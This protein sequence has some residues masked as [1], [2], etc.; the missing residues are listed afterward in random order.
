MLGA[1]FWLGC[2]MAV[3]S[4]RGAGCFVPRGKCGVAKVLIGGGSVRKKN[5][6][7]V[8]EGFYCERDPA[9]R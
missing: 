5:S 3:K 2:L 9:L 6:E 7:V 8:E 1:F 4:I